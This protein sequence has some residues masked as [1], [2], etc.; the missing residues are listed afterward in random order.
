MDLDSPLAIITHLSN[1]NHNINNLDS[2]TVNHSA[3]TDIH[4]S[5]GVVNN[6]TN[7]HFTEDMDN[8]EEIRDTD[9]DIDIIFVK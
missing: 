5:N 7:N 9:G 2:H 1:A 3:I 6:A 8:A 4:S